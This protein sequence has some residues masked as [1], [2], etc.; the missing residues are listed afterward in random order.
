MSS[1]ANE[2]RSEANLRLRALQKLTGRTDSHGER[3]NASAAFRVLHDLALSPATGAAALALLHELQV[4]QVE[5]DLQD[6]EM[7]SSC[8]ELEASLT[9]QVQLYDFAPAGCL[10]VDRGTTLLGLNLTAACMLGIERDQLLGRNLDAFVAPPSADALRGML[11]R[12]A[13]GAPMAVDVLE[14]AA[15]QLPARR[16]HA[17]ASRDPN[18]EHFLVALIDGAAWENAPL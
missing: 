5:L 12:V 13:D 6:E 16:V 17:S 8:A 18:G 4:Y 11:A 7:R 2:T 14:L 15:G 9:R 1:R 10:N 3:L